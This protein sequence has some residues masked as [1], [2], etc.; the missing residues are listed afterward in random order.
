MA[1]DPSLALLGAVRAALLTDAGVME[2]IGP[3]VYEDV[4]RRPV[5]PYLT[6]RESGT[7]PG[8]GQGYTADDIG[9]DVH[10]WSR[11]R[12]RTSTECRLIG[13]AVV[14]ALDDADLTLPAPYALSRIVRRSRRTFRD[15]DNH[16]WHGVASFEAGVETTET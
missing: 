14:A 13:A 6:I 5:F 4:P 11:H 3:R 16:T 8:D 1:G 2:H 9:V 15:P 12:N 7:S 10:V